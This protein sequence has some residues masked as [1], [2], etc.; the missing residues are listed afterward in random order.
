M[1]VSLL[2]DV[3]LSFGLSEVSALDLYGD[4]FFL[5]EGRIQRK[6]EPRGSFKTN[7][8]VYMR[9]DGD[10][11][12][13]YRIL[14]ED[15]FGE[16][17][18]EAT[19]SDFAIVNGITY[20][21]RQATLKNA[22]KC[23]AL[24]VDLDG[25]TEKTLQMFLSWANSDR[26]RVPKPNYIALSGH[27]VHLYWLFRE[28]INLYPE[29]KRQLKEFK[30][31]LIDR[32]WN[33]DT[34]TIER[35]QFQGINQGFRPISGKTKIEGTRVRAFK[36]PDRE[37]WTI[38]EMNDYV[39][40]ESRMDVVIRYAKAGHTIQEAKEMWP[41]WYKRRIENG[42]KSGDWAVNRSLYEWW[43]TQIENGATYHHRYYCIL[44]L[45]VL[46]MRCSHYDEK[47]NPNPVTFEELK[48]DAFSLKTLLNE[49][50]PDEPFTDADILSALEG[51]DPDM[52]RMKI[53]TVSRLSAIDIK[54][55]V[56]RRGRDQDTHLKIARS[57]RDILYPDG[58][59][60]NDQG[61]P[62]KRDMIISFAE[63]HP[64][65]SNRMIASELGVS[66]NTVNKWMKH[67]A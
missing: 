6:G 26:K 56:K 5:G 3:L 24:I 9:N 31:A 61:A 15:E 50:N 46:A 59:W 41:E 55:N 38:E 20:F 48:A 67:R 62:K 1:V 63:A 17:L 60:R 19:E 51:F 43:K 66:R 4:M 18:K 13:R 28:P 25:Q 32:C 27:N 22:S 44:C 40:P 29:T 53:E 33:A 30:Y 35:K 8:I 10:E 12:G 34:S 47:K 2:A 39:A 23:Y 21:G 58:S 7:P 64:E 52:Q 65:Y 14:F 49:I 36:V 54:R 45:A 11:R 42:E 16:I 57:T 37:K